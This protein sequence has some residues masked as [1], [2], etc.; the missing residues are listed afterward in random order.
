[1]N[2]ADVR[3]WAA[4]V[5]AGRRDPDPLFIKGVYALCNALCA[6]VLSERADWPY[7]TDHPV[8]GMRVRCKGRPCTITA[9]RFKR[10]RGGGLVI[11]VRVEPDG[12]PFD[13]SFRETD[14]RSRHMKIETWRRWAKGG[15]ILS[16]I[17]PTAP[18][19]LATIADLPLSPESP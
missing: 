15:E 5:V 11:K 17:E 3:H 10:G 13:G 2:A 9:G 14:S 4:R 6:A 8:P 7:D 19:V 16:R 12:R 18:T 1:M